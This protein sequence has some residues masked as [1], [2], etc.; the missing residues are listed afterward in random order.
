ESLCVCIQIRASG[1]Q[2]YRCHTA[3]SQPVQKL[4][5]EQRISIVDQVTLALEDSVNHIGQVAADLVHPQPVRT[6]CNAGDFHFSRRQ[7]DEE[8]HYESLQSTL[9]PRFDGEEVS[10]N[11][12][13]PVLLEELLPGG[14]SFLLRR[15]LNSVPLQDLSDRRAT[16]VVPQI[17]ECALDPPIAPSPVLLRHAHHQPLNLRSLPTSTRTPFRAAVVLL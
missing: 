12:Q 1:G 10:G 6:R 17:G 15:R 8:Q 4:V 7:L 14:L 13:L 2:F 11:D 5:G 3:C 16:D 9:R